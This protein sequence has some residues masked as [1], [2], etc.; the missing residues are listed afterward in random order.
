MHAPAPADQGQFDKDRWQ[1]FNVEEDRAEANDLAD[2]HPEK[3]KEL[4]A[5]WLE[6]AKKKL[7]AKLADT[8]SGI[9]VAQ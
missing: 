9:V 4:A 3:V 1:L 8:A 7:A 5:L 6:E 2:Q